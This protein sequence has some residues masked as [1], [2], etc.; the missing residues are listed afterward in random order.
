[1]EPGSSLPHS[2]VPA[3]CP[4]SEPDQSSPCPHSNS[5]RPILILSSS[6]R[7]GFPHGLSLTFPH[8]NSICSPRL[9]HTYYMPRSSHFSRLYHP[10]NIWWAN[11]DHW[12]AHYVVF[13]TVA[14]SLLGPNILFSAL[15]SQCE[16]PSFTPIQNNRQNCSYVYRSLCIFG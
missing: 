9:P 16:R 14:S 3:A 6:L 10:N 4:C 15:Y 5:W 13:S 12:A 2:Q 1:M 8:Q 7:L 11:T